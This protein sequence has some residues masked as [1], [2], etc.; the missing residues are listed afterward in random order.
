MYEITVERSS[1]TKHIHDAIVYA[2]KLHS[3][4]SCKNT[5]V[6]GVCDEE[7]FM[8][9]LNQPVATPIGLIRPVT[10]GPL[11][12]VAGYRDQPMYYQKVV[13]ETDDEQKAVRWIQDA[14]KVYDDYLKTFEKKQGQ[15][16]VLTYNGHW[17]NEFSTARRST[18]Y[19]PGQTYQNIFDDLKLFY[20]AE[21]DYKRLD[22]PWTRTYMLHGLPGTGKTTLVSRGPI[23]P[24]NVFSSGFQLTLPLTFL[25]GV[26]PRDGTGQEHGYF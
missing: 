22:I 21:D 19:L 10:E 5:M 18:L 26:Y 9:T 11:C 15:L 24:I 4:R 12:S 25:A 20:S 14:Q 2:A 7:R 17:H 13:I 6:R 3:R 23:P 8:L 1:E 16:I